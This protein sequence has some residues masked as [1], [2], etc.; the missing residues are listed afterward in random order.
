VLNISA[1]LFTG[2]VDKA[3]A[4][5]SQFTIKSTELT[6]NPTTATITYNRPRKKGT[7]NK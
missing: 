4:K 3:Q 1:N 2:F 6:T 5:S 7:K